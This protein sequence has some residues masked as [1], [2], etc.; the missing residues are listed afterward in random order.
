M[1]KQRDMAYLLDMYRHACDVVGAL[2]LEQE[3]IRRR[4]YPE[5]PPK[6]FNIRSWYAGFNAATFL[7]RQDGNETVRELCII[8]FGYTDHLG[9]L[10]DSWSRDHYTGPDDENLWRRAHGP[11]GTP[12]PGNAMEKLA[13]EGR[14][15]DYVGLRWESEA[16]RYLEIERRAREV[17]GRRWVI[18]SGMERITAYVLRQMGVERNLEDTRYRGREGVGPRVLLGEIPAHYEGNRLVLGEITATYHVPLHSTPPPV[19]KNYDYGEGS[20]KN[21]KHKIWRRQM[22]LQDK[23]RRKNGR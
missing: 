21:L 14:W 16:R 22:D 9:K 10:T 2:Y 13:W 3:Q 19:N 15:P 8:H 11:D 20:N 18:L 12:F 17:E 4:I 5:K 7:Q 1:P 23:D 6:G